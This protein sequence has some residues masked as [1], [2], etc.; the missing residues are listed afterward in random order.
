MTVKYKTLITTAGAAKLAAATASGTKITLTHMA[1]GDGGGTLPVPDV[2]QTK[3]IAEKWRAALNKISVDAKNKNYV[4]AELVIPPEVG[5]FWLREMGLYDTDGTL[6]AVA[7]MAESYKPELAE[8]SGRAQTLRMVIIVSALES[9]ELVIDTTTVMA[10]QDYVD[11]KLAEHERS[12]RHPDATLTAKGFTQLSNAT[13]SDSEVL[14]AT[15]KAVKA[16]YDLA[17]AK[18]TA[19]DATTGRKGIVQLNSATDS[20]SEVQ[21]ATP[22]AVKAAYDLANGKY[23]AQEATTGRK[24]IVQLSSATDSVSEVL[25]ATPKAVKAANDNAQSRL[26]KDQNGADIPDRDLFVRNIGAGRS[27]GS[28][29]IGGDSNPWTT[30]EFLAWLEEKGAFTHP[31]WMVKG[32]WSYA[33]NKIITDTGCGHICLAGAVVEVMG[34]KGSLTLRITTPTTTTGGG[35]ASA[36]FTYIHHGDDYSPGWRRDYNTTNKP[37]MTFPVGAPIPWPSDTPPAGYAF[38]HGQGFDK[39]AYPQLAQVYP[40]GVLPDLRG[41]TLKGKPEG[42]GVLSYEEDGIKSH[43]HTASASETDLG[44][45]AVSQF[46]YGSKQAT[47]FDY[48]TKSTTEGGW[49]AHNFR[50]CST[51]AYRDTPGTGLGMHASNISWAAGDRIDGSGNHAHSVGIGAHDHWVGIGAHNHTVVMGAHG[52][53]ITVNATGNAENTVKNTAINYIVRLA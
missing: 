39:A 8:G 17:N 6:V 18:Y 14:S 10:T 45:K 28:M 41:M 35:V 1:V 46:D 2:G 25:A 3:L 23:T 38:L 4:V 24:G 51:S 7:N 48:G 15:P 16:V 40:S 44:T 21:A 33:G 43:A 32:S 49:H 11:D 29:N 12:R 50:Y 31:Y 37:D 20:T 22:K 42:R 30:A 9:V 5:G 27:V 19:Q 36:Q 53:A 26:H 47:S 52:H 34:S 13:D